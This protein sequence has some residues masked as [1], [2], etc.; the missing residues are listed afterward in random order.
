VRGFDADPG[1][2]YAWAMPSLGDAAM[3]NPTTE[4]RA[5]LF[6][7]GRNQAV[8]IPREFELPGNEVI[9]HKEG[10]RLIVEPVEKPSRLLE[11]LAM[12]ESIEEPF[13]D[14]DE[15]LLPLDDVQL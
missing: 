1:S 2:A 4:R 7:N 10:D 9:L 8:R 5:R 3:S 12:L 6:R 13:P 15:G 11:L 14:V